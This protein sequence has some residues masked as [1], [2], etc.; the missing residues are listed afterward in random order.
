MTK[1]IEISLIDTFLYFNWSMEG[2]GFGQLSVEYD[3]DLD[4]ITCDNECMSREKVR[5]IL[6]AFANHLVDNCELEC[7][8]TTES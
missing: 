7:K 4:K 3:R 6:V 5:K 2:V 8:P 1:E